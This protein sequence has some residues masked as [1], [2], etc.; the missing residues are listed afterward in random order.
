MRTLS[1]RQHQ[2]SKVSANWRAG[3]IA[4]NWKRQSNLFFRQGL[5]RSACLPTGGLAMACPFQFAEI[6]WPPPAFQLVR[7]LLALFRCRS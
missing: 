4:R 3:V 2:A 1:E 6:S 5:L 7:L